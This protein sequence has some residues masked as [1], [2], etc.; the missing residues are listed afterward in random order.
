[1]RVKEKK[2]KSLF[3][4]TNYK[5]KETLIAFVISPAVPA[6]VI[7]VADQNQ[8]A[9]NDITTAGALKSLHKSGYLFYISLYTNSNH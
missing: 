7:Y 3:G 5:I 6:I 2:K 9:L 1:M 8:H 4:M